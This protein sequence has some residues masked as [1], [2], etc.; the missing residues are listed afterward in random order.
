MFPVDDQQPLPRMNLSPFSSTVGLACGS[1]PFNDAPPPVNNQPVHLNWMPPNR[2]H[3]RFHD[4]F[5]NAKWPVVQP[6][7]LPMER[8]DVHFHRG[9]Y[10][11]LPAYHHPPPNPP[12]HMSVYNCC[13]HIRHQSYSAF[14]KR[15][16][17]Q[18][19]QLLL[20]TKS[21]F[22]ASSQTSQVYQTAPP[23]PRSPPP[24][25]KASQKRRHHKTS[26][27]PHSESQ[28]RKA[29]QAS[30]ALITPSENVSSKS[31]SVKDGVKNGDEVFGT[32]SLR[33]S[34]KTINDVP[35]QCSSTTRFEPTKHDYSSVV[36]KKNNNSKEKHIEV[37]KEIDKRITSPPNDN[38]QK[39]TSVP[40]N[41]VKKESVE[42]H[43]R[44]DQPRTTDTSKDY[45][46]RSGEEPEHFTSFKANEEAS[47]CRATQKHVQHECQKKS[48]AKPQEDSF[49]S[50]DSNKNGKHQSC[51]SNIK[52]Y[53][54]ACKCCNVP[55]TSPDIPKRRQSIPQHHH[56]LSVAP[57]DYEE[58]R[59]IKTR[60][61]VYETKEENKNY[62]A[63]SPTGY[64]KCSTGLLKHSYQKQQFTT[65]LEDKISPFYPRPQEADDQKCGNRQFN[66]QASHFGL[67]SKVPQ[68]RRG[69]PRTKG[70]TDD[71]QI[72]I[73][74][75]RQSHLSKSV[76]CDRPQWKHSMQNSN[77][78]VFSVSSAS[79]INN[80]STTATDKMRY[81]APLPNDISTTS[82]EHFEK[83]RQIRKQAA[84]QPRK[85]TSFGGLPNRS[86]NTSIT[87]HDIQYQQ[88]YKTGNVDRNR[89]QIVSST[90]HQHLARNHFPKPPPL[91]TVE[92]TKVST[93][94]Q[95]VESKSPLATSSDSTTLVTS[96][97]ELLKRRTS[98]SE[99]Q[100][101]SNNFLFD[102]IQRQDATK[103]RNK[104]VGLQSSQCQ[105][106]RQES[107]I[108]QSNWSA[109]T[110]E[111]LQKPT[112]LEC[113]GNRQMDTTGFLNKKPHF[114][115]QSSH[116]PTSL[117]CD[118]KERRDKT[119]FPNEKPEAQST[120]SLV[121]I[122]ESGHS[123]AR[124]LSRSS[125]EEIDSR[126]YKAVTSNSSRIQDSY[127][128]ENNAWNDQAADTSKSQPSCPSSSTV[129][130]PPIED[131]LD[132]IDSGC[133]GFAIDHSSLPKIV[134][135]H[136]IVKRPETVQDD[137]SSLFSASD[138]KYWSDLL[139][140]LTSE[141][142]DFSGEMEL[143][144]SKPERSPRVSETST[145]GSL[146]EGSKVTQEQT[147]V[148]LE[149]SNLTVS[150]KKD[151][152]EQPKSL[153]EA[154]TNDLT[155]RE[156]LSSP[157]T[158]L[159]VHVREPTAYAETERKTELPRK[160][161]TIAEL[162]KKILVTR[163]RIK[164]ETIPWKKKLLHSLEAIFTKKLRKTEKETGQKADISF[165]EENA[166]EESKDKKNGQKERRN[167]QSGKEK[168]A[169]PRHKQTT[170]N[171][172]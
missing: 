102:E 125:C 114:E 7:F 84:D 110:F 26:D 91:L 162:S 11:H 14:P 33:E 24:L 126:Y 138:K 80:N 142:C 166:K 139:Q 68:L 106:E 123:V 151:F 72:C 53:T 109:K 55:Q 82:V 77:S 78:N 143:Q 90:Q 65:V 74:S 159:T 101:E 171:K 4:A 45:S 76:S 21:A 164:K 8:N 22:K 1:S 83:E 94:C 56:T 165:E 89:D 13:T 81:Q 99:R 169:G 58:E 12:C 133:G 152:S 132:S 43:C 73:P 5:S 153:K 121:A 48:F 86:T 107:K 96:L 172:L 148:S 157:S 62:P 124:K 50:L 44:C 2:H 57:R 104:S 163:E 40:L 17:L 15:P 46:I 64:Q 28:T 146:V 119:G 34:S 79:D 6:V 145:L 144:H 167:S 69:R 136:S 18:E 160:K 75:D 54:S 128:V 70:L 60:E 100:R 168:M 20:A 85:T 120:H 37:N 130:L 116:R 39:D 95:A 140:K 66:S 38:K 3:V 32:N 35:R 141:L 16:R 41:N 117:E 59:P 111:G 115:T 25:V 61:R 92:P 112:N 10:H 19:D 147:K 122:E 9:C 93:S 150:S 149:D 52:Q 51:D 31:D 103:S 71:T 118:G 87:S 155:M 47:H 105:E 67:E 158:G 154:K 156:Y 127:I 23:R 131:E 49:A 170:K 42:K 63:I 137:K 29:L 98:S 97:N 30:G 27:V 129:P 113:D 88:S 161:L 108:C 134:A 135:V 36:G